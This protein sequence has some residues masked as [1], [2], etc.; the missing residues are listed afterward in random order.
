MFI[1]SFEKRSLFE[2]TLW[3]IQKG[4][5]VGIVRPKVRIILWI[6]LLWNNFRS[7]FDKS[8]YALSHQSVNL[9]DYTY[10]WTN[11]GGGDCRVQTMKTQLWTDSRI[12]ILWWTWLSFWSCHLFSQLLTFTLMFYKLQDLHSYLKES[13][14][15]T[16][17]QVMWFQPTSCN[18]TMVR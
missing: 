17:V 12:P 1:L 10:E 4:G 14:N 2:W 18:W 8:M 5:W 9:A 7:S 3:I 16:I 6:T 13:H 15:L 11:E